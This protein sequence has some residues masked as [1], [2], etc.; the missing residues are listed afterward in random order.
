MKKSIFKENLKEVWINRINGFVI[1]ETDD[2][3]Y[4]C[5]TT[6]H[7]FSTILP[8]YTFLTTQKTYKLK[9]EN[10]EAQKE[11]KSKVLLGS[12]ILL[13][14]LIIATIITFTNEKPYMALM[15]LILVY[16][17][18]FKTTFPV[19]SEGKIYLTIK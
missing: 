19:F 4:L 11:Y 13:G 3:L 18:T 1:F 12:I 5:D 16:A 15:V 2:G 17:V 9:Y 7:R 10:M 6:I 14:L 8:L